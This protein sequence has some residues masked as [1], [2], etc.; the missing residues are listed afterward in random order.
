MIP[1]SVYLR[2]SSSVSFLLF[3]FVLSEASGSLSSILSYLQSMM[4]SLGFESGSRSLLSGIKEDNSYL[5][6]S[7]ITEGAFFMLKINSL[8]YLV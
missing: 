6:S 5:N 4:I 3:M 8:P 2:S 1:F 7:D